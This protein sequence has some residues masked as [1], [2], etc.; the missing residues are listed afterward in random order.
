MKKIHQ[1][2]LLNETVDNVI[3][4]KN[5]IYVDGTIGFGGHA[6]AILSKLNNKGK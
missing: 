4:N 5:G 6:E 1:S 2:V 3:I